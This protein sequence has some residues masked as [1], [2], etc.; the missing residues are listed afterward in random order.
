M[1]ASSGYEATIRGVAD[2]AGVSIKTVSRVLNEEPNVTPQTAEKV[3]AAAKRLSYRPNELARGLKGSRTRTIGLIIAD[4]ANPFFADC[5]KAIEQVIAHRDHALILCASGESL[6][7]ERSYVELLSRRRVDGLLIV[8]APGSGK[9]L[10]REISSGLP[11]VAFDRPA[12]DVETDTVIVSNRRG[13]KEATQ[14]LIEHGRK[15]IAFIGDDER[16]YT[17]SKRL[18]GY[19]QAMNEAGLEPVYR[20]ESGAI[21]SACET[22]DRLLE[23][24]PGID[25]LLG[26]NSLITAGILHSLDNAGVSIPEPMA[27]VGFDDFQLV[28]ALR[29]NLT[30]V[31]QPTSQLGQ[32][33]AQML[34]NRLDGSSEWETQRK[35]LSTELS[36]RGSCGC[37]PLGRQ[38]ARQS[39]ELQIRTR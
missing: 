33:A 4:I 6:E 22:A 26:G 17:A 32:V 13:A 2:E 29:P 20:M 10:T 39:T 12:K 18:E 25:A 14:H 1:R 31:R 7:S 30:V 24:H 5:C 8:P 38:N 21:P 27:V 36:V 15:R 3:L 9:H 16:V 23:E 19:R 37:P 34:L 35:V 28:S 11:I